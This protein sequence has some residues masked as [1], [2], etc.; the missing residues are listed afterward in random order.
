M[1]RIISIYCFFNAVKPQNFVPT[2]LNDFTVFN[3]FVH[4]VVQVCGGV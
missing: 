3:L 4:Q 1:L 2:K